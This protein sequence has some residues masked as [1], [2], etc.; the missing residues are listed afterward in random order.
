MTTPKQKTTW[1][2]TFF[3][4][5][6]PPPIGP[7]KTPQKANKN[8]KTDKGNDHAQKKNVGYDVFPRGCQALTAAST[9]STCST[10]RALYSMSQ[11]IPSQISPVIW[12]CPATTQKSRGRQPSN[13]HLRKSEREREHQPAQVRELATQ[14]I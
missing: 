5:S 6:I 13:E 1:V 2:M 12:P 7:L 11:A 10:S 3:P 8:R 14:P 4:G 9:F